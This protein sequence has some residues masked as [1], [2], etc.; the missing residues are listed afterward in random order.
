MIMPLISAI[1][2]GSVQLQSLVLGMGTS[3]EVTTAV[4]SSHASG[5]IGW[6]HLFQSNSTATASRELEDSAA[7]STSPRFFPAEMTVDSCRGKRF[8]CPLLRSSLVIMV[9]P[10]AWLV[11]M[12]PPYFFAPR[13][14]LTY[15]VCHSPE[16]TSMWLFFIF[17]LYCAVAD[18]LMGF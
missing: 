8:W 7:M 4:G 3:G 9:V 17:L 2:A 12:S 14:L 1:W 18:S 6:W 10:T 15:Q 5:W 11:P 16:I 13:H